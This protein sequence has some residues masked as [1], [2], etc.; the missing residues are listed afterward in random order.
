[1]GLYKSRYVDRH[2]VL[3]EAATWTI[4]YRTADGRVVR[5][6]SG[7]TSKPAA[8]RL[9]LQR[10]GAAVEGRPTSPQ[11]QKV[12]VG[13]LF[14]DLLTEY[15]ANGRRVDRLTYSLAH[16]GPCFGHRRAMQVTTA[17]VNAYIV[18]RQ[19]AKAANGTINRELAALKR[20][21]PWRPRP[22]KL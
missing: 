4:Q 14:D 11:A 20:A 17:D 8:K 6:S 16:L 1:M 2:G 22:T 18:N 7:L 9:L 5:E 15:Q 21:S 13:A 10:A 3:K 12:T 19:G